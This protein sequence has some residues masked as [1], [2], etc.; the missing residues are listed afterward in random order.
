MDITVAYFHPL[1]HAEVVKHDFEQIR[2]MGAGSIVYAIHEQDAQRWPRDLERGLRQAQDAGLKVYLSLGRY[3]NLFAGPLLVNVDNDTLRR[4]MANRKAMEALMS[5]E[6]FRNLNQEI[7]IIINKSESVKKARKDDI[8]VATKAGRRLPK[9]TV[10][11]YSRENLTSWIEDSLRNLAADSLDLVQLHCPPTEVYATAQY[12]TRMKPRVDTDVNVV[13]DVTICSCKRRRFHNQILNFVEKG[14]DDIEQPADLIPATVGQPRIDRCVNAVRI[15]VRRSCQEI[16][17]YELIVA[18]P[19]QLKKVRPV[20]IIPGGHGY[21]LP[22]LVL[23]FRREVP[24]R[25]PLAPAVED[26]RRPLC[27]VR[28]RLTERRITDRA[29]F[30]IGTGAG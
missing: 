3:G 26:I 21:P 9:Q 2:A 16:L 1:L 20:S 11:G 12:Q 24:E 7:E 28:I 15:V 22:Q 18:A 23:H 4:L 19:I 13:V 14:R 27:H 17:R 8:V 25:V 29:A 6:G 5:I 30:P 10:G